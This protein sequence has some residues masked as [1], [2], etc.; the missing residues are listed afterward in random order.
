MEST[1]HKYK[2]KSLSIGN[3]LFIFIYTIPTL[4]SSVGAAAGAA[5]AAAGRG[6]LLLL[7]FLE[8]NLSKR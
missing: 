8:N 1:E 3:V 2:T 6:V 4:L 5:A 7:F